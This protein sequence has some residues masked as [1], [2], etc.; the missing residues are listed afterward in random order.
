MAANRNA[1]AKRVSCHRDGG[2]C[3]GGGSGGA[4]GPRERGL[5]LRTS[6]RQQMLRAPG[7]DG[8]RTLYSGQDP[9][10]RWE[11]MLRLDDSSLSGARRCICMSWWRSWWPFRWLCA[12]WGYVNYF[13][14]CLM[15]NSIEMIVSVW[16]STPFLLFEM[17]INV[18]FRS[19]VSDV[20]EWERK[21]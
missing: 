16:C 13:C 18:C 1:Q 11:V 20:H 9:R 5:P 3:G 6:A 15:I 10:R 17:I 19:V 4:G 2:R 7:P 8:Q 14:V 12:I 21:R